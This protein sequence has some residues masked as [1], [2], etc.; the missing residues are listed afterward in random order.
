MPAAMFPAMAV[1]DFKPAFP[2]ISKHVKTLLT[3]Q[4]LVPPLYFQF[5]CV[6]MC[7]SQC[8]CVEVG[9]MC[10]PALSRYAHVCGA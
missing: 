10:M 2:F 7:V 1:M 4:V 3:S 6:F 5:Q 9:Y 8:V